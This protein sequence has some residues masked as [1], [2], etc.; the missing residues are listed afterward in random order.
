MAAALY[1]AM[2]KDLLANLHKYLDITTIYIDDIAQIFLHFDQ[3]A[4]FSIERQ[5][6]ENLGERMARVFRQTT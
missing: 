4:R 3:P 6:G 2:V 5:R 1:I